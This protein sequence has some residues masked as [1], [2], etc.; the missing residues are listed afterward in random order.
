MADNYI[1]NDKCNPASN[2]HVGDHVKFVKGHGYEEV[3]ITK[4]TK[5]WPETGWFYLINI[6]VPDIGWLEG[7]AVNEADI[8]PA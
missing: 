6:L 1:R 8:M 3:V 2:Y 5:Y 4:L 7:G